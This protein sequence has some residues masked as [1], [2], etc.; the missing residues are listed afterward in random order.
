MAQTQFQNF[1]A[2]ANSLSTSGEKSAAVD[3]FMTYA[4]TRGIP[5]IEGDTVNFLYRGSGSSANLAGDMNGWSTNAASMTRLSSTNFFYFLQRFEMDARLDYKFVIDG[6]TWILDSENPHTVSGGYGPNSEL[7]M[8]DYVQPWEV[9]Y[10]SSIQ[11]GTLITRQLYSV[12]VGTN[13]AVSI[14]LPPGYDTN[15]T[16]PTVYFQD[17]N[18]YLSYGNSRNVIDNLLDSNLI[19]P[20]IGI[21]VTPNNRN[22]E[23]AGSTRTKYRLFFVNELVP[24]IDSVYKTKREASQRLV[25][26]DSYGGNI[27]A[28]I[29]FHHSDVFGNCGL[30]SAAFQPNNYEMSDS[31]QH[32]LKKN[33]KIASVWGSYEPPLTQNLRVVT[34]S[35]ISKGYEL[36]WKEVHE[37]HSWGE[38]RANTDF[39]LEDIFPPIPTGVFSNHNEQPKGFR[40]NQNYPNPFNPATIISYTLPVSGFVN[41][42]I[43]NILGQ[44]VATLV[45][46]FQQPGNHQVRFQAANLPS[47]VYT[48]RCTNESFRESKKMILMK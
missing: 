2:Y 18:D 27:S 44:E 5:F 47:G 12:N 34:D 33:I 23:Y 32:A 7:A 13:Y 26:G 41:L 22:E 25:I 36:L 1:L 45:Q 29:C 39:I 48:Y 38:W 21:F 30:H 3:S 20:V 46:E 15:K 4:R 40:L 17:G 11:H 28:L 35:L 8:P 19:Q 9:N 42:K 14:Y 43:Y 6:S 24:Y 10:K 31:F 37:G 16:Y